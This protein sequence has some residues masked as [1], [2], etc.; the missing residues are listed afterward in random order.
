ME[1]Q[2]IC[3]QNLTKTFSGRVVVDDLS[4]FR[5]HHPGGGVSLLV[6]GCC[7][8]NASGNWN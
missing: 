3:V 7:K 1:E 4:F 6:P 2:C 5:R 8:G